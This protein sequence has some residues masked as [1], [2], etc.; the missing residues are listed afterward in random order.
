MGFK[1][2]KEMY[3]KIKVVPIVDIE[4]D[5][6]SEKVEREVLENNAAVMVGRPEFY[7]YQL[8]KGS[9]DKALFK[10]SRMSKDIIGGVKIEHEL[11]NF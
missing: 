10:Q 5:V 6:I 1:F 3:D 2:P 4:L 11:C 9:K 7:H 8:L